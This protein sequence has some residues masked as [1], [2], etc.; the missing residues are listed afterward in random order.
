MNLIQSFLHPLTLLAALSCGLMAGVFF[1]FS[2][3]VMGALQRIQPSAGITVMQSINITVL[4]PLFLG[5]FG[6][7]AILSLLLVCFSLLRW[8]HPS[9]AWL[10]TGG[11]L[12]LVG[13][14]LATAA[15]NVPLNEALTKVDPSQANSASLWLEFV[16]SWS[17][18]NHVRTIAAFLATLAFCMGL[19]RPA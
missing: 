11:L 14:F 4:N 8:Q 15:G 5:F 19:S 1:A 12:Y 9:S 6:G 3:F 7:T 17:V 13:T 18:W 10:L 16:S 2:N